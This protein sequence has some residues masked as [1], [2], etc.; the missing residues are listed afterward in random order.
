MSSSQTLAFLEVFGP[1]RGSLP[2]DLFALLFAR[3]IYGSF[4]SRPIR[5]RPDTE[6]PM[7]TV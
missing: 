4:R 3:T 6:S 7:L 5:L 2:G 1:H